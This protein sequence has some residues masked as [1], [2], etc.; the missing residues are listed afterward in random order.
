MRAVIRVSGSLREE[1]V[2]EPVMESL[3]GAYRAIS[4]RES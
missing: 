3:L 1:D 2:P 4:K